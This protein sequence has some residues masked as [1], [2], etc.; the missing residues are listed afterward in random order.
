MQV[1][2]AYYGVNQIAVTPD[3]LWAIVSHDRPTNTVSLVNLDTLTYAGTLTVGNG[4]LSVATAY[5]G[6][7]SRAGAVCYVSYNWDFA[8]NQPVRHTHQAFSEEDALTSDFILFVRAHWEA[9]R[10]PRV[11]FLV[12]LPLK[13]DNLD[14]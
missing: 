12:L 10:H 5:Q 7:D 3:D 11:Q 2:A 1:A 9:V 4:A 6:C 8:L 14:Y 13:D